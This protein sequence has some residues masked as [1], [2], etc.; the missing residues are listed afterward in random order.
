[1]IK[2][3][4]TI[5]QDV[6]NGHKQVNAVYADTLNNVMTGTIT[7]PCVI[8]DTATV[9]YSNL[10]KQITANLYILD[11]L[12]SGEK[13]IV[14]IISQTE[15]I[16]YDLYSFLSQSR[17]HIHDIFSIDSASVNKIADKLKDNVA[18][19]ML[20]LQ[21]SVRGWYQPQELPFNFETIKK[22]LYD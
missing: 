13:N 8:I 11:K 20:T 17:N 1:M 3:I 7:Y 12:D 6:C 15:A 5:L 9:N 22:Y 14:D 19:V 18:G 21:L 16:A 4:T 10:K 2:H